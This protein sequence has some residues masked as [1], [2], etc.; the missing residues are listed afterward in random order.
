[1]QQAR[2]QQST[3][4]LPVTPGAKSLSSPQQ[5]QHQRAGLCMLACAASWLAGSW[6]R[7]PVRRPC[8]GRHTGPCSGEQ[9]GDP[10]HLALPPW[11]WDHP[12]RW[13]PSQ[14]SR[15]RCGP[16]QLG[17]WHC[18]P[19]QL[20]RWHCWPFQLG[21]WHCYPA[22]VGAADR[23]CHCLGPAGHQPRPQQA[24]VSI[25]HDVDSF[26]LKRIQAVVTRNQ[27]AT[28]TWCVESMM[29]LGVLWLC[30]CKQSATIQQDP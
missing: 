1:M 21:R 9:T 22:D 2:C 18:W 26:T 6:C 25:L 13:G 30:G 12:C 14:K 5:S 8:H 29:Q 28:P 17:R 7:K 3:L 4:Q 19:F 24:C 16:F 23:C 15:W 27:M 11:G 10:Q 20:G